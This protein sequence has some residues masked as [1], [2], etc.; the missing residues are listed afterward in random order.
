MKIKSHCY[1]F[2]SCALAAL[3]FAACAV[4]QEH[5]KQQEVLTST[6]VSAGSSAATNESR[7]VRSHDPKVL[8]EG[9]E[10]FRS[11]CGRCHQA[12][13]KFP[14]R[15]MATIVRHMRVRATLTDEDAR[16]ILQY[17]TQ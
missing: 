10:R 4:A 2:V 16:L 1:L 3:S 13:R 8:A 9:E 7:P 5:S 12:P 11:N 6:K 15:M 14:P 17:M